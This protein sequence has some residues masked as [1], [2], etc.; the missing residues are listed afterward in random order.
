M[1]AFTKGFFIQYS[2]L[3]KQEET[4]THF[5]VLMFACSFSIGHP[6]VFFGSGV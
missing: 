3:K 2:M 4:E 1:A 5:Q 6:N